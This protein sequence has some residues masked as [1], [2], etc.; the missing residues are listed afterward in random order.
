MIFLGCSKSLRVLMTAELGPCIFMRHE[1]HSRWAFDCWHESEHRQVK[2]PGRNGEFS[3]EEIRHL[4]PLEPD[5][6]E[7]LPAARDAVPTLATRLMTLF[8]GNMQAKISSNLRPSAATP[9]LLE[10]TRSRRPDQR[11]MACN[12]AQ[13]RAAAAIRLS[14]AILTYFSPLIMCGIELTP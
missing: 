6:F 13:P 10:K 14:L 11:P 8:L 1:R 3:R 12:T 4:V 7:P 2:G 9:T 5:P